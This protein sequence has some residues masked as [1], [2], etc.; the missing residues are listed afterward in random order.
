MFF[1][2]Y[3][4]F[5][6]IVLFVNNKY[7]WIRCVLIWF[8]IVVRWLDILYNVVYIVVVVLILCMLYDLFVLLGWRVKMFFFLDFFVIFVLM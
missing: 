4:V 6:K 2:I 7:E 5:L 1:Y 8:F 3:D